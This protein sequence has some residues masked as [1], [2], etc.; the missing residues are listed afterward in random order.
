[1]AWC[2]F[3]VETLLSYCILLPHRQEERGYP[4]RLNRYKKQC[5]RSTIYF[6]ILCLLCLH[7]DYKE[8]VLLKN[9]TLV[10]A[11]LRERDFPPLYLEVPSPGGTHQ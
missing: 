1:M 6:Y 4:V 11:E 9:S 8:R 7:L 2:G 10:L 3:L 5:D